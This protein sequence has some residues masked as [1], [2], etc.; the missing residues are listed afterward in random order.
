MPGGKLTESL[1]LRHRGRLFPSMQTMT[2]HAAQLISNSPLFWV[3]C[4]AQPAKT[5]PLMNKT[6]QRFKSHLSLTDTRAQGQLKPAYTVFG[7]HRMC[8]FSV[9]D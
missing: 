8:K 3:M 9:R 4:L 7:H 2:L 5:P 6:N 1:I